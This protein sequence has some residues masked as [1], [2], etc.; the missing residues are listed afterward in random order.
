MA[1]IAI[2]V[3]AVMLWLAL[4]SWMAPSLS[5]CE[6]RKSMALLMAWSTLS[7]AG[8]SWAGAGGASS[9][10][11]ESG[12][13]RKAASAA[14]ASSVFM[15]LLLLPGLLGDHAEVGLDH[16]AVLAADG[17]ALGLH[18]VACEARGQLAPVAGLEEDVGGQ[19][20]FGHLAGLHGSALALAG[21][22]GHRVLAGLLALAR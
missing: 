11:A 1:M 16:V 17:F 22:V 14:P 2:E 19:V 4:G 15:G 10:A 9:G 3:I 8:F 18:Q 7:A 12:R 20:A 21:R 13:A 5:C 6:T